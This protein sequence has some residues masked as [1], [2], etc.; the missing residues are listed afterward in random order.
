MPSDLMML[1]VACRV[2]ED[3]DARDTG[4]TMEQTSS[5]VEADD[6]QRIPQLRRQTDLM[7]GLQ[8]LASHANDQSPLQKLK[9][10]EENT[11]SP[12][13]AP[14]PAMP[15][16][17][18][19]QLRSEP[20]NTE[21]NYSRGDSMDRSQ[22]RVVPALFT[23]FVGRKNKRD[24]ERLPGMQRLS[25]TAVWEGARSTVAAVPSSPTPLKAESPCV[26]TTSAPRVVPWRAP[27]IPSKATRSPVLAPHPDQ[28]SRIMPVL[29][30]P[31]SSAAAAKRPRLVRKSSGQWRQETS[32]QEREKSQARVRRGLD[33]V[34]QGDYDALLLIISAMEEEL[35]HTHTSSKEHYVFQ[36]LALR[37]R[38]RLQPIV[39]D[40]S[41]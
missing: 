31:P 7:L 35:L 1:R 41:T 36:M 13:L 5:T 29:P 30:L 33:A 11:I 14:V 21:N 40:D 26:L 12:R 34:C 8:A 24:E 38:I 19:L 17:P 23:S 15:Q 16:V 6:A 32:P 28:T 9:R 2:V 37:D 18:L 22:A 4:E 27:S 39:R 25:P 10:F 3:H 20:L